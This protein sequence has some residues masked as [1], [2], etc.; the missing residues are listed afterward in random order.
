[1][2]TKPSLRWAVVEG[3]T[4]RLE[5]VHVPEGGACPLRTVALVRTRTDAEVEVRLRTSEARV[6]AERKAR[7]PA[8]D[9]RQ[10]DLFDGGR[11]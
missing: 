1:M 8:P 11:P 10:D 9:A 6:R 7:P 2:S 5:A 3:P 4:G